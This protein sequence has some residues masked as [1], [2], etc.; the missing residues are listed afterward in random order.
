ML[1]IN[2]SLL[3]LGIPTSPYRAPSASL[4]PVILSFLDPGL[5]VIGTAVMT[6]M[7]HHRYILQLVD[8]TMM[9]MMI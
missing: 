4:V 6:N 3:L 5:G 2:Y 1:F 7:V 8:D 9:M